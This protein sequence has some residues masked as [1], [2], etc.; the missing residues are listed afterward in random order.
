MSVVILRM[1]RWE[2][3]GCTVGGLHTHP[4]QSVLSVNTFVFT[5]QMS[6]YAK[7]TTIHH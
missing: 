4:T 1:N 6:L 5:S 2:M 3:S 7:K